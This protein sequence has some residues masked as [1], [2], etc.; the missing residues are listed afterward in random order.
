MKTI[1]TFFLILLCVKSSASFAQINLVPNPSF[2]DYSICPQ[3]TDQMDLAN[4]WTSYR[5]TPD[6][7]NA[8]ATNGMNVPN[9]GFGYQYAHSGNAMAGLITFRRPNSPDGSNYREFIGCQ[10][11]SPLQAGIKY[12]ISF[13]VNFANTQ[14]SAIASNNIGCNFFNVAY[15]KSSPAP[16][17]NFSVLYSD[18]IIQ[19]SVQ[20]IKL[21]GSFIPTNSYQ[22]FSI[23]NFFD[24]NNTDTL[25]IGQFPDNAYYYIDDICISTDSSYCEL[26]TGLNYTDKQ[27]TEI[28]CY[29]N[30]DNESIFIESNDK[31]I[32]IEIYDDFGKI[33]KKIF[34]SSKSY[35]VPIYSFANGI[36]LI[37]INTQ[38]K[39]LVKKIF[40]NH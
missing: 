20:W 3:F 33:I 29:L 8:C 15:S 2:E 28:V 37:K 30:P 27:N 13:F 23:G 25:I 34:L 18:S 9:S 31:L 24:D 4:G 12:Y 35:S 6:Y 21:S 11:A 38:K 10:L 17:T 14:Y 19:D 1:T 5:N 16:L 32:S 26:W 7:F 22:Y 39:E 36:Y 40:I